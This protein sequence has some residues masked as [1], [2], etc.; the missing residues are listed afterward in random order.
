M[1]RLKAKCYT[2]HPWASHERWTNEKH[3]GFIR[4]FIPKKIRST[5]YSTIQYIVNH[6]LRKILQYR[7]PYE[8]YYNTTIQYVK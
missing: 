7:T 2:A 3:N 5:D 8:V 1:K 4:W 6:K